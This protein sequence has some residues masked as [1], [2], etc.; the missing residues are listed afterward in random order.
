MHKALKYIIHIVAAVFGSLAIIFA[1]ASWRLS[2][3][4]ISIAFLSPYIAEAFESEDLSY[5]LEFEDTILTWAGWNRS[6]DILITDA[7]AVGPDGATIASVPEISLELSAFALLKGA[8][9]PT[10]VELLR[11]NVHLVRNP[12]GELEFAFGQEFEEPDE[13]VNQL[14]SDFLAAP[15]SDH[16]LGDLKRISILAA[17]LN[18][19]DQL[20]GLSW[21]AP[22][23]D[24]VLNLDG[25]IIEGDLQTD[26][27]IGEVSFTVIAATHFDRDE[28]NVQTQV[29]IG[30]I[31]PAQLAGL[32]PRLAVFEG[33]HLPVS[34]DL[35][36]TLDR[37]GRMTE[38][39]LFD[40]A[41]GAGT[42]DLPDLF[43]KPPKIRGLTIRG[44]ADADY[45]RLDFTDFIMDAGGPVIS[46]RGRVT[47]APENTGIQGTFEFTDMPF[48]E[49]GG[50]W[51]EFLMA[52]ARPWIVENV[53]DGMMTRFTA[54]LDVAPGEIE[55]V[56]NGLRPDALDVVYEFRDATVNYFPGQPYAYGVDGVGHI[57]GANLTMDFRDA[58]IEEMYASNGI[59]TV[60]EVLLESAMMTLVANVEGPAEA[61]IALLD[62][63][64]LEYPSAMGFSADQFSGHVAAEVGVQMPFRS[65]VTFEEAQFAAVA[66]LSDIS[67]RN[68]LDQ[69]GVTD[70]N[71][72]V[73]LDENSMEVQGDV[74]VE[75]MP[76]H[77]R[78]LENF[79]PDAAFRSRYDI[80]AVLDAAA[81]KKFGFALAPY[82][83]G[84]FDMRATH[85]L[86]ND[87][88]QH[89][90]AALDGR[91][92]KLDLPALFW[93]KPVGEEATILF[94]AELRDKQDVD[95]S[96]FEIKTSDLNIE[97]R[98]RLKPEN[99]E[100]V[101]AELNRIILGDNDVAVKYSRDEDN[102]HLLEVSGK[103]L[104]IRP[105]IDQLLDSDQGALPP[106]ILETDVDR[107]I[108]RADQ[109]ITGARARV[110]NTAERLESAVLSG[111]L[112]SGSDIRL[113][114]EPDGAKRRLVVRS[115][116]AG[117]VARA[118]NIYDNALG[119]RLDMNATL[120][121]DEPGAPVTGDV[122]IE[123]Y[124]VINAP[125]LAQLLA[126][127]SF[128]GIFD[129]LQGEGIGFSSFHLPFSLEGDVVTITDART[130]G[131]SIGVNA[132]GS[133]NL[134]TDEVDVRGTIV[135]AY[136]INSLL[137]DIPVI[138]DILVGGEGEGIFA[139]NFNITGTTEEPVIV[140]NPLSV[141][142][143]GFLRNLFS[144]FDGTGGDGEP[145]DL[146]RNPRIDSLEN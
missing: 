35:R 82:A 103:S 15:G 20:L 54:E 119:G 97:G 145:V 51:P 129:S 50:Y 80:S 109:Q 27:E 135:P 86:S 65:D 75:G 83:E 61:A 46:F 104:D 64:G 127:A 38:R 31:V 146:P 49:L 39:I 44:E 28:S 140:V 102:N 41:G 71:F 53:I 62:R 126:V 47:G 87:G 2:S 26:I 73:T 13:A 25:Q 108:T 69:R 58:K 5:K 111:T 137:G 59:A 131:S 68:L 143:P 21:R 130:A 88:V 105:Y 24:L 93:Q 139:A 107:L 72:R 116:D 134:A 84:P 12:R 141:L 70:G 3:G 81:Q 4:P 33:L 100:L 142:T 55:L 101:S 96:H 133:V 132:S 98:A 7:H 124:R 45:G 77:I 40:L 8:V 43:P 14:V 120:H 19:E 113:V 63:P 48:A 29:R 66:R 18:V 56:E 6:L 136:A 138:G 94:R 89:I 23:A 144:I 95:L 99:G 117:S 34:G 128:T 9:R 92:A 76:S 57:D 36:F 1:V 30:E 37:E 114:I 118:F 115:D 122:H 110:V 125:T 16:P 52:N 17:S 90:T 112:A 78:W 106:F 85:T 79:T 74:R 123:N 67:V 11:P 121:D 91:Q 22:E 10:S 60:T 42:L 32:H